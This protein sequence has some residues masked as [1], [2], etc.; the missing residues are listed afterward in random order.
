[1][2]VEMDRL[3][4]GEVYQLMTQTVMPRPIAWVLTPEEG[5]GF[6]LAPFSYFNAVASRPPLVV[7]SVDVQP[8]G[9]IKDTRRNIEREGRFV[10][11]IASDSQLEDVNESSAS[12]PA[13]ES[14]VERLN[15]ELAEFEGF[16]LPRL[17]DC[18][19][20][21]GCRL[22]KIDMI[23]EGQ[24]LIF[25]QVERMWLAER[26]LEDRK[27][28]IAVDAQAVRPLGRLGAGAFAHFGKAVKLKRPA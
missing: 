23:A 14:E 20:A 16:D 24:A 13:G 25:G 6:N 1:M 28:R 17:A 26:V 9:S 27:D 5:G 4:K 19:I 8:D 11:H 10:V 2:N 18:A 12:L 22:H 3:S 21:F 7:I 15:L